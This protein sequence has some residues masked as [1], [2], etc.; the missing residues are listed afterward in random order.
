MAVGPLCG[1][2]DEFVATFSADGSR[3]FVVDA[4]LRF[5]SPTPFHA[6]LRRD[7]DIRRL[8]IPMDH[9]AFVGILQAFAERVIPRDTLE[10]PVPP[11][12]EAMKAIDL[13][14][15]RSSRHR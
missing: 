8:E 15:G 3:L 1:S 7:L 13:P 9:A 14:R 11:R 5:Q 2:V 10:A 6:A 12:E 4:L